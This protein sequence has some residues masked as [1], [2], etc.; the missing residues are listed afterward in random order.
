V[1]N[2]VFLPVFQNVTGYVRKFRIRS[3]PC[4]YFL[5]L[6]TNSIYMPLNELFRSNVVFLLTIAGRRVGSGS[7]KFEYGSKDPEKLD[8]DP[9]KK[10][11]GSGTLALCSHGIEKKKIP[12]HRPRSTPDSEGRIK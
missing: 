12:C 6:V 4:V 3:I 11:F 10:I 2:A 5:R 9:Y 1:Y 7:G 8:P